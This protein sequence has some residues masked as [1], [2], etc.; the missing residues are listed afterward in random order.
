MHSGLGEVM[1]GTKTV[2]STGSSFQ[3]IVY[4]QLRE[5][6]DGKHR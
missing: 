6:A 3:G 4:A 2:Q 1:E 5:G